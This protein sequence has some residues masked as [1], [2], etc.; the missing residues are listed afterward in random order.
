MTY[1]HC[2]SLQMPAQM[3]KLSVNLSVRY[4]HSCKMK[5]Y[6]VHDAGACMY[7]VVN[8]KYAIATICNTYVC[9][10]IICCLFS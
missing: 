8:P 10:C 9:V 2:L 5:T 3:Y 4:Y 6:V 1:L 7:E